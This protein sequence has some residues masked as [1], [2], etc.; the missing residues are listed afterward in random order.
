M[1]SLLS[2]LREKENDFLGLRI[3]FF[4]NALPPA[5]LISGGH[6][7]VDQMHILCLHYIPK[8]FFQTMNFPPMLR[9]KRR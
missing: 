7:Q 9:L 1:Y 3:L 6:P 4:Q 8:M 5:K 2:F